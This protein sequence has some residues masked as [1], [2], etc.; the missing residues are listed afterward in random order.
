[1]TEK[2]ENEM[3]DAEMKEPP[4]NYDPV[5]FKDENGK[6]PPWMSVRQKRKLNGTVRKKK[7]FIHKNRPW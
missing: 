4:R 7:K 3:T 2:P 6:F 5:T 1:M